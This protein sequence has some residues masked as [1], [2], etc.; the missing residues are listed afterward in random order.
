[1][2][3]FISSNYREKLGRTH[4]SWKDL[5]SGR[6]QPKILDRLTASCTVAINVK[7]N[8]VKPAEEMQD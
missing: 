5:D 8:V 2:S 7:Y 3:T 6:H 4:R 1:M